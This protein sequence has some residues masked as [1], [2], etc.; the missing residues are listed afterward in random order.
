[1][2]D[3][4]VR[5]VERMLHMPRSAILG[6][7]RAGFVS[8]RR[9]G[10]HEYRFSFQDLIVLRTARALRAAKVPSRRIT[11]SLRDLRRLLPDSVP[12]SGLRISA[13]GDRVVVAEGR[14]KWQADSGQYVLDLEVSVD[15]GELK[16]L[17]R[18]EPA[19]EPDAEDWFR[20]G[21][22]AER[23]SPEG[24]LAAYERA[25]ALDPSHVAARLNLGRLLHETAQLETAERVY[26]EGLRVS[27]NH[28]TLLFNLGVLLDD[29]GRRGDAIA[30]YQA[31]LHEDPLFADCHYNLAL[32]LEA[33]GNPRG[34]IRHM[35]E[36]RRL[37]RR[38]GR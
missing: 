25:L 27:G 4:G 22:S 30:A 28:P 1:M 24:A 9:G 19:R 37:S 13:V 5:D 17:A 32:L 34:A 11:R 3:F 38:G 16:L 21:E 15:D 18:D 12:L 31:A 26:R 29:A 2:S 10:R 7:V 33:S 20:R 35:A 23:D 36:Y 8:P 6:L 14:A